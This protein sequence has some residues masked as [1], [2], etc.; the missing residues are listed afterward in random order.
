MSTDEDLL[1]KARSG[2]RDALEELVVRYQPRVYRYGISMCRDSDAASDIA[3]ETLLA[4]A[5]SVGDFR[6]DSSVGTWLFTIARRFCMRK[7]RRSKF[8]PAEEQ[9]LEAL[10]PDGTAHLSD[11]HPGPEETTASREV[12]AA[13]TLAIDTLDPAQ[14][15]VLVLR[16]V[17]GL[18]AS[19]VAEVLGLSV[20]AVKSRLHRARVTVRQQVAPLLGLPGA[21][22]STCPDVLTLFSRHLEG[23]IAPRV[24][25][26][27]EAHLEGCRDCRGVCDSLKRTLASCRSLATEEVPAPVAASVKAAVRAFLDRRHP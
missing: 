10:G 11:P 7:R 19:E 5:R 18:S 22:P 9:S 3:Q 2:D 16:D 12:S 13:L 1:S 26:E 27:M 17:E 6:G 4:M 15:E 14:R 20:Q 23:D 21:V 24:C 8:A 25:A